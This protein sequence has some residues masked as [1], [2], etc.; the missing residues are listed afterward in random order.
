[1]RRIQSAVSGGFDAVE[2]E[3]ILDTIQ[4]LVRSQQ[5]LSRAQVDSGW[6]FAPKSDVREET[7]AR[8]AANRFRKTYR[9]IRPLLEDP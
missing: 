6:E 3:V 8:F 7:V 9:S 1:M 2:G 4:G 5:E